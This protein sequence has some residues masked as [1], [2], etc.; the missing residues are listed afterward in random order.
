MFAASLG[1]PAPARDGRSV[2][3]SALR[4]SG[5]LERFLVRPKL[6]RGLAY[7]LLG[8]GLGAC[9]SCG[10]SDEPTKTESAAATAEAPAEVPV[11][12]D[13]LAEVSVLTPNVT[14]R[15]V[16]SGI[17]GAIGVM[18]QNMGTVVCSLA[19]IDIGLGASIDGASSA[20]VTFGGEPENPSWVIAVKVVEARKARDVLLDSETAKYVA[21]E[22]AGLTLLSAKGAAPSSA[23][24]LALDSSGFLLV[25]KDE[26]AVR[27]LGPYTARSLSRKA[28]H[29][30]AVHVDVMPKALSGKVRTALEKRWQAFAVDL[31]ADDAKMRDSRGGRAPDFGDPKAIVAVADAFVQR[32]LSALASLTKLAIEFDAD[33]EDLHL[34][35]DADGPVAD[36]GLDPMTVGEIAPLLDLPQDTIAA[37]LTRSRGD[38]RV[39][40]AKDVESALL[41]SLGSRLPDAEGKKLH[42]AL[43]DFAKGRGDALTVFGLGGER[44]AKGLVLRTETKGSDAAPRAVAQIADLLRAPVFKE[45]L[46]IKSAQRSTGE[47][48][49]VGKCD[50]L[51]VTIEG[52]G[53]LADTKLGLAW[54]VSHAPAAEGQLVAALG[55]I[56]LELI[57]RGATPEQKIGG[58]KVLAPYITALGKEASFVFF[59]QPFLVDQSKPIAPSPVVLA[60][61]TGGDPSSRPGA[62]WF[63]LDVSDRVMRELLKKQ[64][65]L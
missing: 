4:P 7:L 42:A 20:F 64:L 13:L 28:P 19:G 24:G 50:T 60:W 6:A 39:A 45:P 58:D 11:P 63:R 54:G 37:V 23:G 44:K 55:D 34:R 59:A 31:L 3:P 53:K 46:R 57:T 26:A 48:R 35:A 27:K 65:G 36:G 2:R 47:A 1:P 22:E 41:A 15:R 49:G 17:G 33:A 43:D 21:K 62:R 12:D 18:P 38:E 25:G 32:R 52:K 14:W 5:W 9:G 51:D 40:D 30:S 10:K 56:P 16:Q 29:T 61:G 8:T